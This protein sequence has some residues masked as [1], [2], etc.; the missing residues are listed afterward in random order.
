MLR[1]LAVLLLSTVLPAQGAADVATL[2]EAAEAAWKERDYDKAVETHRA[3]TAAAP[4]D[5][6]AWHHLGYALHALGRME[7]ALAAHQK[8][9]ALFD[10]DQ[11][12]GRLCTYNTACALAILG[13]K[14]DALLWLQKAVDRGF[15]RRAAIEQDPDFASLR[16]DERFAKLL[17]SLPDRRLKVAVVVH[18]QVELLDFAGPAEVFTA[19]RA[20]DGEALFDVF[21]VAPKA[22]PAKTQNAAVVLPQFTIADA[23]QADVLVIPGGNTGVLERDPAFMKWVREAKP[24]T[25]I[26]LTVCTGAFIPAAL[27]MLDGKKATTHHSARKGLERQHP[28]IQVVD[29]K[30]VD[31]GDIVTA[32]GVSSGIE[33]SLHV[34]ARLHG[35]EIAQ[36][37]AKYI[38]YRWEPE[39][40]APAK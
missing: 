3:L 9:A 32:A 34:V 8:G 27:G 20:K 7:E 23:P 10:K 22:G 6:K 36:A 17:A 15:T 14:D 21:L 12:S 40:T 26:L 5:V 25:K 24:K 13:K 33:G 4:D 37:A 19:A 29:A 2:R 18:D 30:F 31:N 28:S 16:E 38:E 1:S 39:A 11:E 35:A